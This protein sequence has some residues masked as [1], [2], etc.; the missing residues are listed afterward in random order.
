MSSVAV[1]QLLTY[2]ANHHIY[3]PSGRQFMSCKEVSSYLLSITG[4]QDRNQP[5]FPQQNETNQF[6]C[7]MAS[8]NVS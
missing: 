6:E 5:S 8:G 2:M 4:Q 1:F 7:E 3:S